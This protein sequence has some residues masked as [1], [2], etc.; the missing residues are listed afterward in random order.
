MGKSVFITYILWLFGGIFGLHHLYLRRDRHAFTWLTT[1]GGVFGLG[2]LREITRLPAY[3]QEANQ[4]PQFVEK[5][6]RVMHKRSSPPYNST[7]VAGELILGTLFGFVLSLATPPPEEHQFIHR[8]MRYLI[9]AAVATGVHVVGNIG[10]ECGKFRWPLLGSYVGAVIFAFNASS[11]AYSAIFATFAFNWLS[12]DWVRQPKPTIRRKLAYRVVVF[13]TCFLFYTALWGSF[14]WFNA[15]LVSEDGTVTTFREG[16]KN[17]LQSKAWLE[18]KETIA[19]LWEYGWTHGWH[20]VLD[21]II[22][23]LDP[24]GQTRAYSILELNPNASQHE[25]SAQY[26]K[27]SREWHPDRHRDPEKKK[28]AERNFIEIAQA[29]EKLNKGKQAGRHAEFQQQHFHQEF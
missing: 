23:S 29:Y 16:V 17:F 3:V 12:R 7:R 8:Y 15:R 27:L 21:E 24:Y 26:R 1:F 14:L 5:R 2:W 25:I 22:R 28:L 10:L 13:S 9:P 20:N 19:Q 11:I 6:F 4:S 18:C